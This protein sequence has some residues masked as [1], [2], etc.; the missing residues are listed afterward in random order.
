[1][2]HFHKQAA[3]SDKKYVDSSKTSVRKA[4]AFSDLVEYI[5]CFRGSNMSLPV[6]DMVEL[7]ESRLISLGKDS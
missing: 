3:A 7:Y 6:G 5:E 2:G 1:M 4:Q